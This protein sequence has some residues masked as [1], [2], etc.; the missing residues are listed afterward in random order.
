MRS[1]TMAL[2]TN[3]PHAGR[4]PVRRSAE[5]PAPPARRHSDVSPITQPGG[6]G[7]RHN[8][9]LP[10]SASFLVGACGPS[11]AVSACRRHRGLR[12]PSPARIRSPISKSRGT[13]SANH[14]VRPGVCEA[15]DLIHGSAAAAATATASSSGVRPSRLTYGHRQLRQQLPTS[16][17]VPN[18]SAGQQCWTTG[19]TARTTRQFPAHS[20]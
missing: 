15:D 14:S 4:S 11:A 16:T 17:P 3:H 5:K 1:V 8:R 18:N 9:L 10:G 7:T 2:A 20:A 6:G 19:A 13:R 12:R